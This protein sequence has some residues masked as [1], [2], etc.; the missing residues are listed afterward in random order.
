MAAV[1]MRFQAELR[2]GWR[3]WL[4]LAV[5]AGLA[6][7][8]VVAPRPVR[9]APTRRSPAIWS[10]T[11]CPTSGSRCRATSTRVR[12]LPQVEA[13]SVERRG[14][15]RGARRRN[16]PVLRSARGR[17]RFRCASTGWTRGARRPGKLLAGRR[18]DS[19]AGG[20][21]RSSTRGRRKRSAWSRETRSPSPLR[22]GEHREAP[23]PMPE[24]RAERRL[25]R[26]RVVG[27]KAATD[28]ADHPGGVVR[29][30][31]ALYRSLGFGWYGD[32]WMS[33]RLK[34]GPADLPDSERPSRRS[35]REPTSTPAG[36]AAKIQRSIHLQAQALRLAGSLRRL[37]AS[38]YSS[39]RSR[40]WPPLPRTT[41]RRCRRW[42]DAGPA[43]RVGMARAGAIGVLA[44]V[45][46][47]GVA[48]ALS[49][50]TPIGQARELEPEP[51]FAFDSL[52]SGSGRCGV[53]RNAA[54]RE[55]SSPGELRAR[56]P[57]PHGCPQGLGAAVPTHSQGGAC[58]RRLSPAFGSRWP[59][60]GTTACRSA[61]P[62]SGGSSP[63]RS[64]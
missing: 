17:W 62:F 21:R 34:R 16:R 61:R 35:L 28:T 24:P 19:R 12:A 51:G 10:C 3:S 57:K 53:R 5:L 48:A 49:P 52:A 18:A 42:D 43:L 4:T 37:L 60:E 2:A 38:C 58:R 13:T 36:D 7:G 64:P 9:A 50:L 33:V 47:V 63:S 8:L 31:P 39:K 56:L 26:L 41:T 20:A 14:R 23:G 46:A 11:A 1:W 6:G 30:T 55:R 25:V 40:G 27:I 54:R 44:A 22:R 29:L 45:L 59:G 15:I 32:T